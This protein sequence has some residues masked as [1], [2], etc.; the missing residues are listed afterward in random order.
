MWCIPYSSTIPYQ[1]LRRSC[2][3]SGCFLWSES[4]M[5]IIYFRER[6][7]R[8]K[9]F[10]FVW[11]ETRPSIDRYI[12][13]KTCSTHITLSRTDRPRGTT[14]AFPCP[15]DGLGE[16]HWR[17]TKDTLLAG[18]PLSNCRALLLDQLELLLSV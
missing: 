1:S 18:K 4:F 16:D 3:T 12:Y 7:P 6:Q 14:F 10:E 13:F 11:G 15:T 8:V 2:F 9:K 5:S 17:K